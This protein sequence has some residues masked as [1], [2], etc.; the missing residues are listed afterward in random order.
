MPTAKI[1]DIEMSYEMQ[2]T[3]TPA[4][5]IHGGFGG[6]ASTILPPQPRVIADILPLDQVQLVTYDR[7][8]AGQ[9]DYVLDEYT[10]DDLAADTRALLEHPGIDRS[11]VIGDSMG[12]MVA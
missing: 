7:R 12:G 1:N 3:G 8:C 9:T 11:I 4:L 10:L 5:F 6:T 2:G